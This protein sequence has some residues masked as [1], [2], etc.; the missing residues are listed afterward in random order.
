MIVSWIGIERPVEGH[1]GVAEVHG[2]VILRVFAEDRV[3]HLSG[4][5]RQ[6][7][8]LELLDEE[9]GIGVAGVVGRRQVAGAGE[10]VLRVARRRLPL[11]VCHSEKVRGIQRAAAE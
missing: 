8:A 9:V 10:I 3:G 5:R 4:E 11:G 2:A 6:Q 7:P 1:R